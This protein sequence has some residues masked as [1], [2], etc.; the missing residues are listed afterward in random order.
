MSVAAS[1]GTAPERASRRASAYLWLLSISLLGYALLGKGFAYL[2]VRP[3]YVSELLLLGGL[4]TVFLS[5]TAHQHLVRFPRL[6]LPLCLVMA[7]GA[8]RTAPYIPQYGLDAL[9]DA[10]LWGYALFA[11]VA[12]AVISARPRRLGLL[13]DRY[14]MFASFYPYAVLVVLVL[15]MLNADSLSLPGTSVQVISPKLGDIGVHLGGVAILYMLGMTRAR[16]T[17]WLTAMCAAFAIVASQ[18]RGGAV[19]FAAGVLA[20]IIVRGRLPRRLLA[21][22]SVGLCLAVLGTVVLPSISLHQGRQLSIHQIAVNYLSVLTDSADSQG[23]VAATKDWRLRW[24]SSIVSYTVGGEYFWHGKG[25]GVNLA[26]VDG[27]QVNADGSLRSPHNSHLTML[28]RSGVPGFALWLAALFVWLWTAYRCHARARKNGDTAWERLFAFLIGYWVAFVVEA[29]FD[30]VLEG[31]MA[32]VWFWTLFGMGLAA[33]RHYG[34]ASRLSNPPALTSGQVQLA[35]L[36]ASDAGTIR[37][38][39]L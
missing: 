25:F 33:F 29:S 36:R 17:L 13:I 23:L 2:G 8:V 31:P 9:R 39:H 32:G 28:A 30:V 7:W 1:S 11:L 20:V 12:F 3:V 35:P 34:R 10:A 21:L 18:N 16:S 37:L 24:W 14:R 4:V 38:Q 19:A 5:L 15:S 26:D 27:F 22:T 6:L